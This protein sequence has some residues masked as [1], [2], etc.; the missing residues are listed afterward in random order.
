MTSQE[1]KSFCPRNR[2]AWRNWLEK[3]HAKSHGVWLI[4][5]KKS[6]G[7]KRLDYADAVEEALC[8]GWIDSTSRP[9]DDETYMQRFT[10]RKPKSGWSGLNKKRIE[11]MMAAGL[12]SKAGLEKIDIAKKDGSWRSLDHIDM[13]QLPEDFEKALAKNKKAKT[14]FDNFPPFTKKQFLY[15]INSAKRPETRKERIKL[16]VK[17]AAGNKKPSIE[18]FKL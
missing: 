1:L 16:C 12:M 10:P 2:K 8:F 7:K 6:A 14:N 3:N 4:Y 15:R 11:K 13:I 9:I 5:Y 17:M 18:G